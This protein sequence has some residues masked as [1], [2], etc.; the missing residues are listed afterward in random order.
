MPL[1]SNC[2]IKQIV[3]HGGSSLMLWSYLTIKDVGSL[4]KIK[5]TF[6]VVGYLELLHEEL[7]TTLVDFDFD[8][9]KVIF[10]KDDLFTHTYF[11]MKWPAQSPNLH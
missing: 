10:Q 11:V 3:K 7:F 4:Y 8:S 9:N 1:P 5:K 2:A 6:N